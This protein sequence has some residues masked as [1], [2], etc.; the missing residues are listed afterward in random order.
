M[1]LA[2]LI[3][4]ERETSWLEVNIPDDLGLGPHSSSWLLGLVP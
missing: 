2:E 1:L 4:R 3:C